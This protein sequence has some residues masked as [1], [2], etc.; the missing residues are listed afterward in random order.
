MKK[1]LSEMTLEELWQLFPIILTPHNLDWADWYDEERLRLEA[2]LPMKK[3]VR[4]SHI[5]STAIPSIW[6]KP[7]VDIL[8]ET[9]DPAALKEPLRAAGYGLMSEA[10]DRLSFNRGYTPDGFAERVFHLHVRRAGDHDELY[11]RDYLIDHP[12][13]AKA[14]EAL[15]MSLW[16]PYEH[17]RDGYTREK[18]AFVAAYTALAKAAYPRKYE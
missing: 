14:Y 6:A 5:G 16:K 4:A 10:P 2:F 1:Q 11:F 9:D 8:V 13:A 12:D 17:D 3:I 7:T 15:K 18:T